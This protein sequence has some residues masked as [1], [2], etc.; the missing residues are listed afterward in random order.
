LPAR[1]E[2]PCCGRPKWA[3]YTLRSGL[4]FLR[5]AEVI[6]KVLLATPGQPPKQAK[7]I[8]CAG[9]VVPELVLQ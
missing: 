4:T 6:E 9:R 7:R 8:E 5:Y 1:E 3:S 2:C